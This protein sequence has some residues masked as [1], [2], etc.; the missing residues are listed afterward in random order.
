MWNSSNA[1]QITELGL[2][3]SITVE[4]LYI[5]LLFYEGF[6][7]KSLGPETLSC[8]ISASLFGLDTLAITLPEV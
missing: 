2:C 4:W 3:T 7:A 5:L 1:G 8:W 6:P